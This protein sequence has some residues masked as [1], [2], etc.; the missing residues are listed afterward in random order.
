MI[1]TDAPENM[2]SEVVESE[3]L[4]S[5]RALIIERA[6]NQL[7]ENQVPSLPNTQ[8]RRSKYLRKQNPN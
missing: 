5:Q 7:M 8:I 2:T 3:P 6:Q 4:K 1:S